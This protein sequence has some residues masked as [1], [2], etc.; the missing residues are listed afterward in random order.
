MH[1]KHHEFLYSEIPS[2]AAV[3]QH[4]VEPILSPSNPKPAKIPCFTPHFHDDAYLAC[5]DLITMQKEC[6]QKAHEAKMEIML[7]EKES[8]VVKLEKKSVKNK[9][10]KSSR[11]FIWK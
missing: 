8:T 2:S 10:F 4:E 7:P 11:K 9:G 6:L 5:L 1:L 3:A